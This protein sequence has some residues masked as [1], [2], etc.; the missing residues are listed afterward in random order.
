MVI[1]V[2][3]VVFNCL[4]VNGGIVRVGSGDPR[5]KKQPPGPVDQDSTA[6]KN[7]RNRDNFSR[8]GIDLDFPALDQRAVSGTHFKSGAGPMYSARG[9]I[10][11]LFEYCS[12][13]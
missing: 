6:Y 3:G 8:P 2:F 9:R 11:R 12:R 1:G 5:G 10:N 7:Q 13:M 4:L